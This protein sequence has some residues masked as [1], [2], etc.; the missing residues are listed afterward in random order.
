LKVIPG[1]KKI[2]E[3]IRKIVAREVLA[4]PQKKC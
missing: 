3:I 2:P 4:L 1:I